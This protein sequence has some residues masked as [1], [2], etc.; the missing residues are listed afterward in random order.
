MGIDKTGQHRVAAGVQLAPGAELGSQLRG[1][2]H[3]QDLLPADGH[4]AV[5]HQPQLP[6]LHASLWAALQRQHLGG[7][8][9]QQIGIHGLTPGAAR[10]EPYTAG[11]KPG[12]SRTVRE[13][14]R[15]RTN[16]S[17]TA[18]ASRLSPAAAPALASRPN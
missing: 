2:P 14:T 3:R 18:N 17:N 8:M 13:A 9:D 6:K 16:K 5:L 11:G 1:L 4:R 15:S 7:G 12:H 10:S